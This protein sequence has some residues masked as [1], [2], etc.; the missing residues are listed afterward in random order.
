MRIRE[1]GV[2]VTGA[3]RGIGKALALELGRRRCRVALVSRSHDELKLVAREVR[4]LGGEA[5]AFAADVADPQAMETLAQHAASWLG[6][7][8]VVIANAG[9]GFHGE[10]WQ[11]SPLEVARV[12]S[13]NFLGVVNTIRSAIPYLRQQNPSAV[14]VVSSLS[15]LIPYRGGGVYAASKAA[16]NA[17]LACLRLDLRDTGTVVGWVCPGPVST[18]MIVGGVPHRKLP[19]LARLAVPILAPEEVAR[20]LLRVLER[21]GGS[22]VIPWQAAFFARFYQ[23]MPRLAEWVL[24]V[25]GAGSV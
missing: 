15:A 10:S 8:Q 5:A 17:Y 3:S 9:V 23:H 22:K 19:P 11:A 24:N 14:G 18:G 12:V 20:G 1:V 13:V 4:G 6:R 7:W 2:L 25:T 16:I 21:G